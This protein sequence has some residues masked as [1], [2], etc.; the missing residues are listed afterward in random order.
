MRLMNNC[1][2]IVHMKH[3]SF[4]I[5]FLRQKLNKIPLLRL[6]SCSKI[7]PRVGE[8]RTKKKKEQAGAELGQ[9]QLKLGLYLTLHY[10]LL[11]VLL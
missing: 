3:F 5:E 6:V 1:F 2:Q 11:L 9:A 8:G 10:T 7:A 4:L